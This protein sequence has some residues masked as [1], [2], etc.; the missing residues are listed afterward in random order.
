MSKNESKSKID[1]EI[2]DSKGYLNIVLKNTIDESVLIKN[3]R[4]RT[5]KK[6]KSKHGFG[7]QTVADIV[8]KYDGMINAFE[9]NGDFITDILLKIT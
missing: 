5:S 6:D 4:L 1:F 8:K 2:S 7:L 3:P 9:E